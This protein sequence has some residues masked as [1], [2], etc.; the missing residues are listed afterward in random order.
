MAAL[1]LGCETVLYMA[2]RLMAYTE[3]LHNLPKTLRRDNLEE[4]VVKMYAHILRFLTEALQAF[5]KPTL[6]RSLSAIWKIG[7]IVEFEKKAHD[8]AIKIEI[9][10]NNC[11]RAA[12][13]DDREDISRLK[14]NLQQV[15]TE[16]QQLRQIQ[17]TLDRLNVKID[18]NRIP[19]AAGAI[20]DSSDGVHNACHPATRV[21]LLSQIRDWAQSPDG[22][23]IFW[24]NGMAGTGKSTISWTIARWLSEQR[25]QGEIDLGASFFFKRGEGDRGSAVRFFPTI[26]RQ[27]MVK[28]PYYDTLVAKAIDADPFIFDKALPEQFRRLMLQ[29]MQD[30]TLHG[31]TLPTFFV[32]VDALDE[33]EKHDDV[34]IILELWQQLQHVKSVCLRLFLTSRPDFPILSTFQKMASESHLD[35]ILQDAV[36]ADTLHYDLSVYLKDE[37]GTIRSTHNDYLPTELSLTNDWPAEKDLERLVGLA[38]P[39]F[40]VAATICRFVGDQDFDPQERL[41]NVLKN[42]KIGQMSHMEMTYL[43]VLNHLTKTLRDSNEKSRLTKDFQIIVGSIIVLAEPLSMNSLSTLLDVPLGS[44]VRRLTALHSVIQVPSDLH[45][46][47]RALH[48]SFAEFLLGD[49]MRDQPFGVDAPS[50]HLSLG[51]HC[52]RLLSDRD[53]LCENIC[54]LEYPGQPRKEIDSKVI[55][56][57]LFPA[58]QYACRHWVHHVQHGG[59]PIYDEDEVHVFLQQHFLHWLEALSLLGRVAEAIPFVSILQSLVSVSTV[60]KYFYWITNHY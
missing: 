60:S 4:S 37:F 48:L 11:D 57:R 52:L 25:G 20:F 36:P 58:L 8:L 12:S 32:V 22:K 56:T 28:I 43:P 35:L 5:E 15:L 31:A 23:S 21:D 51:K 9:D 41:N 46:P 44:V 50:T 30:H 39:L 19:Y 54:E 55:A 16:L 49:R 42:Q 13:A 17:V 34:R 10:A 38:V 26:V 6:Q 33:C 1:L 59:V 2:N 14:Q 40:I 53:G 18:L 24:L 3:F 29:P 47:V 27:L 45:T 7:S